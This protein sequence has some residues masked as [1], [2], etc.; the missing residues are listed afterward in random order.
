MLITASRL[1]TGLLSDEAAISNA[2]SNTLTRLVK[3]T[4]NEKESSKWNEII[5]SLTGC[6]DNFEIGLKAFKANI[7]SILPLLCAAAQKYVTELG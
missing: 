2:L 4:E 1:G 6:F 5:N 7:N 3:Q